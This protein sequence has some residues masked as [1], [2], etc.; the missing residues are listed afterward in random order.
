M[1]NTTNQLA[2]QPFKYRRVSKSPSPETREKLSAALRG[3]PKSTQTKEKISQSLQAYWSN[4]QNFP[5]DYTDDGD[6]E[7]GMADI[8]L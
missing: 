5:D 8:I 3:K 6:G 1:E 7:I 4:P 2:Q